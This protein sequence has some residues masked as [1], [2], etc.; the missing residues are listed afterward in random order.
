M[1]FL[2]FKIAVI[3]FFLIRHAVEV[4]PLPANP[5]VS[6]HAVVR[7]LESQAKWKGWLEGIAAYSG[8][9]HASNKVK[10]RK[11]PKTIHSQCPTQHPKACILPESFS[12]ITGPG[13][14]GI[15]FLRFRSWTNFFVVSSNRK[16]KTCQTQTCL[17]CRDLKQVWIWKPPQKNARRPH[18]AWD[19]KSEKWHRP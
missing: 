15:C 14:L 11:N 2:F 3:Q 10:D 7:T 6:T 4:E 8:Y 18:S 1:T 5:K 13:L 17:K 16:V 19:G 12:E 9:K